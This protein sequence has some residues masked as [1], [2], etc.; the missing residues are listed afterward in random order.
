M[1]FHAPFPR[2]GLRK[3]VRLA[4]SFAILYYYMNILYFYLTVSL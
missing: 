2:V 4:D 3:D 1:P